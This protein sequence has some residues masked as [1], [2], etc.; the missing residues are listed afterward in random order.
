MKKVALITAL[1][2]SFCGTSWAQE[3]Q[4]GLGGVA[5]KSDEF[6]RPEKSEVL[7]ILD[8]DWGVD[9]G[10][11]WSARWQGFIEGPTSG[12]VTFTA[13]MADSRLRFQAGDAELFNTHDG[14]EGTTGKVTMEKGKKM[15]VVLEFASTSGNA[16]IHLYWSWEG[17]EQV[18]V[19]E[20][21]LSHDP[22]Q[23]EVIEEDEEEEEEED[24]S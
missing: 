1:L 17:Q 5:Y 8:H 16:D 3:H 22:S 9:R 13:K 14:S 24:N 12:E 23:I 6:T 21:A 10:Q 7:L 19:P 2:C 15:P 20:S 11:E 18:I 4:P